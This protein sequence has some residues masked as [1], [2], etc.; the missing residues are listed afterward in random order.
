MNRLLI[1]AF[2]PMFLPACFFGPPHEVVYYPT[3][4]KKTTVIVDEPQYSYVYVEETYTSHPTQLCD[5]ILESYYSPY[6]HAPDFC[7]DYGIG[8]GYCCTWT[9]VDYDANC[10]SE[11]C[12]WEDIC[13][14]EPV[15][16]E[17]Y[18]DD[19]GYDYY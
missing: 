2:L 14:W 15:I 12:F 3:V 11:W 4:E 18:Y 10:S 17:C 19:F 8:T 16:D 6:L 7:T 5:P 9:Y 1:L 13:R